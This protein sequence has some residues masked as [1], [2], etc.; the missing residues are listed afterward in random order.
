ML[1]FEIFSLLLPLD[2]DSHSNYS[3]GSG[4]KNECESGC[5]YIP[6]IVKGNVL[7]V[8]TKY[9][10]AQYCR[11]QPLLPKDGTKR[12]LL[13]ILVGF[14]I[15]FIGSNLYFMKHN[16]SISSKNNVAINYGDFWPG[17]GPV[18]RIRR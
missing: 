14:G 11:I 8:S 12:N 6:C 9:R 3:F 10:F 7:K 17:S 4:T 1:F 13:E 15:K 2:P 5:T 18:C 16:N